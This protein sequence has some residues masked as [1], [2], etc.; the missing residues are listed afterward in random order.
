M[1]AKV[2]LALAILANAPLTR[3]FGFGAYECKYPGGR[4]F[5]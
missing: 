4:I 1:A 2:L 3:V 5:Y